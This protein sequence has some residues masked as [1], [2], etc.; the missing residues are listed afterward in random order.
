VS[1]TQGRRGEVAA[2][3]HTDFPE[4]F[5]ERTRLFLLDAAGQ[6]RELQLEEHWPHKG[7]M[8]LKFRGVDSINDAERLVGS[9]VQ[10]P[11]GE[12]APLEAG[13]TYISDLVGCTLLV[14]EGAQQAVREVGKIEDVQ[15]GAGEA[16]LLIVRAGAKE[17]MVPLAQE[18][19]QQVDVENKRVRMALPEGMLE[20]DAP[21]TAEEK[22]EQHRKD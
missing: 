12:R 5:A 11:R 15:F 13:E 17:Y 10:I 9:E 4:L 7:R 20:L 21:L 2:D 6:R 14:V 3:L 19:L 16:P 8:V 1:K 18:F 22:A